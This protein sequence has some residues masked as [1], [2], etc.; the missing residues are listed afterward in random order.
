MIAIGEIKGPLL[1]AVIVVIVAV[2][3][4]VA[5][6]ATGNMGIEDRYNQALGLPVSGEAGEGFS[7]EGNQVLYLVVLGVLLTGCLLVYRRYGTK[8][9]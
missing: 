6:T 2:A 1:F 5:Y 8:P 3:A 9:D 7:L 4:L